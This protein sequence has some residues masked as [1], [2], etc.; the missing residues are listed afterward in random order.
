MTAGQRGSCR[1]ALARAIDSSC[2]V[3]RRVYDGYNSRGKRQMFEM[4]RL[5][6]VQAGETVL[7]AT[8]EGAG[9]GRDSEPGHSAADRMD[10][11]DDVRC[12]GSRDWPRR[13]L[14][15]LCS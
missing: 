9:P 14:A 7:R 3:N 10:A 5:K 8:G 4:T 13:R 12:A 1:A 11:R 15:S 6:I 2:M